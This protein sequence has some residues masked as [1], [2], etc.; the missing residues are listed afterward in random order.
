[1][2]T[3]PSALPIRST[4]AAPA[5]SQVTGGGWRPGLTRSQPG[6]SNAVTAT[7]QS[8]ND[9][10]GKL[11]PWLKSSAERHALPRL[12]DAYTPSCAERRG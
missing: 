6:Q 11:A 2:L 1:M 9:P 4:S 10:E 5:T 3:I 8:S 12:V 7:T